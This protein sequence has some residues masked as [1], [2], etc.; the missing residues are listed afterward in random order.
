[1]DMA[2]S[3]RI[4]ILKKQKKGFADYLKSYRVQFSRNL[5]ELWEEVD[6]DK[7]GSLDEAEAK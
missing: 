7:N 5:D 4:Q 2:S 6:I 3:K 1:M